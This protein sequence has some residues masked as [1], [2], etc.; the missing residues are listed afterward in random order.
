MRGDFFL[1]LLIE[2][3]SFWTRK[4][5]SNRVSDVL[6]ICLIQTNKATAYLPRPSYR[7]LVQIAGERKRA[8]H[9]LIMDWNSLIQIE[10][11]GSGHF[12][13]DSKWIVLNRKDRRVV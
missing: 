5:S 2:R 11:N 13:T 10:P 4:L 8:P 1:V 7:V 12:E 9:L 3:I 6:S